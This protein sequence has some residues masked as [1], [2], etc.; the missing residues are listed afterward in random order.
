MAYPAP[1]FARQPKLGL[2]VAGIHGAH[3]TIHS[4]TTSGLEMLCQH[5]KLAYVG[6]AGKHRYRTD[7]I[8]DSS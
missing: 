4:G 5:T 8:C 6:S 2:V 1:R 3:W 7:E